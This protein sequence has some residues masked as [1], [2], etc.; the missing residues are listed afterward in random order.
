MRTI[1]ANRHP[2][3]NRKSYCFGD[4]RED[5]A[6]LR[7]VMLRT[8]LSNPISRLFACEPADGNNDDAQVSLPGN[9]DSFLDKPRSCR[10]TSIR[11]AASDRSRIVND[12]L[13]PM[14]SAYSRRIR[15]PTAWKVPA[16][17]RSI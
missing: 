8:V 15:A 11:S 7:T 6:H 2:E 14:R 1:K 5:D 13:R 12:G 10:T 3:N 4:E 17:G 9:R 16:H